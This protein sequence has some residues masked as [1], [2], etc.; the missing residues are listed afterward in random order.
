MITL[1]DRRRLCFTVDF[2][3]LL[4]SDGIKTHRTAQY[5]S[6]SFRTEKTPSC[7]IYPPSTGIYGDSGWTFHDYG[8]ANPA[9][10]HGDALGYLID[11]KGMSLKA[12][13]ERIKL[14]NATASTGPPV[15]P[16]TTRTDRPVW[17]DTADCRAQRAAVHIFLSAVTAVYPDARKYGE[18][19]LINRN[20]RLPH[21]PGGPLAFA[22]P[23]ICHNQ[24]AEY[25]AGSRYREDLCRFGL[26]KES[27]DGLP[28][29]I[30]RSDCV[31]FV[32][33]DM[34]GYPA[35]IVARNLDF[36]E[37][38]NAPKYIN[39]STAGDAVS[40]PFGISMLASATGR[41]QHWPADAFNRDRVALIVEGP[42]D[43]LAAAS[44]G[45]PA[46]AVLG[47]LALPSVD[48]RTFFRLLP[49]VDMLRDMNAVKVVP[50]NDAATTE[51][52]LL[53]DDTDVLSRWSQD[54]LK[55]AGD[56][57]DQM[58]QR[59]A[60]AAVSWLRLQDINAYA[61]GIKSIVPGAGPDCKDLAEAVANIGPSPESA[62][63]SDVP[64]R[65]VDDG[66]D[67]GIRITLETM[68]LRTAWDEPSLLR[69][70][71][72]RGKVT[73]LKPLLDVMEH[74][75]TTGAGTVDG[76]AFD[77]FIR[78]ANVTCA[79]LVKATNTARAAAGKN[80]ESSAKLMPEIIEALDSRQYVQTKRAVI[81]APWLNTD[82][83]AHGEA[84]KS[85]PFAVTSDED[86]W[87]SFPFALNKLVAAGGP[88]VSFS[89]Q[90][91]FN[92]T[93]LIVPRGSDISEAATHGS[94][95]NGK[96]YP[97]LRMPKLYAQHFFQCFDNDAD[98]VDGGLA[99]LPRL[100]LKTLVFLLTALNCRKLKAFKIS[101][102][103]ILHWLYP[104]YSARRQYR[105]DIE[106]LH[107]SLLVLRCLS[108]DF[109]SDGCLAG[110][111]HPV[112][113]IEIL[114]VGDGLDASVRVGFT[115]EFALIMR[116]KGG[117]L[118]DNGY[119][120]VNATRILKLSTKSPSLIPAALNLY[121]IWSRASCTKEG[122]NDA[123]FKAW[124][125]SDEFT[126]DIGMFP[127]DALRVDG[128]PLG[129]GGQRNLSRA[130]SK[131]KEH[132]ESLQEAGIIAEVE[133]GKKRSGGGFKFRAT[134]TDSYTEARK[135]MNKRS[136]YAQH[137]KRKDMRKSKGK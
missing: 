81:H 68:L 29:P 24:L 44:Q 43:A 48:S 38:E 107:K 22:L 95:H 123:V 69:N 122:V 92:T 52:R 102:H 80:G 31:C 75:P 83:S 18:K 54:G 39:Q 96:M 47:T 118:Y 57:Q 126:Y 16:H 23:S 76:P 78:E 13:V 131:L 87:A 36:V 112:F 12:A 84:H 63:Q 129:K 115:R 86:E 99:T 70:E 101:P 77:D 42:V 113:N 111:N 40:L 5:Y 56:T 133:F 103:S 60:E 9:C 66:D 130:R 50:D 134:P 30:W 125:S 82:R 90:H 121:R 53:L 106:A 124:I 62:Q 14:F 1:E 93:R 137:R 35:Y 136:G 51:R 25:L 61:V 46:L 64:A 7:R 73:I 117:S 88:C 132:M 91:P 28:R 120:A 33:H 79:E 109:K 55:S 6:C 45:L 20:I 119:Y 127:P 105:S 11:I 72:I 3:A 34:N 2:L 17:A 41:L 27:E 59:A 114:P 58:A 100:T 97:C 108:V 71:D 116:G 135:S 74:F 21:P 4:K 26:V 67:L 85:H 110:R 89:N 32:C 94:L 65:E 128:Q 10:S 37:G 98:P 15:L 19:Y 104:D 8:G 49:A